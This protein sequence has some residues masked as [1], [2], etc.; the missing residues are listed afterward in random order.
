VTEW[1]AIALRLLPRGGPAKRSTFA[2]QAAVHDAVQAIEHRYEP[3]FSRPAVGTEIEGRGC[4]GCCYWVLDRQSRLP[5]HGS[6][7]ARRGVLAVEEHQRSRVSS[8]ARAAADARSR[9]STAR[10]TVPYLME[11][12]RSA[13]GG[14]ASRQRDDGVRLCRH[15]HARS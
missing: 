9:R 8:S 3:Y 14:A 12:W 15:G 13:N 2:R 4:C 6:A 1:N 10:T 5:R 7:D 11:K